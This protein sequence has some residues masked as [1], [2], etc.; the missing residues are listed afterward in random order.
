MQAELLVLN[1]QWTA[2][3]AGVMPPELIGSEV[4]PWTP[5]DFVSGL[6]I[7]FWKVDPGE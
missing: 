2:I 1:A 3:L 7:K 4:A 5:A 6:D